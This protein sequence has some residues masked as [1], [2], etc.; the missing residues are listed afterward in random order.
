MKKLVLGISLFMILFSCSNKENHTAIEEKTTQNIE[1]SNV[2]KD[3]VLL[4]FDIMKV[5]VIFE[6]DSILKWNVI[7]DDLVDFQTEKSQTLHLNKHSVITTWVETE[8]DGDH[9]TQFADF[10][11][12][13][14]AS[15]IRKKDGTIF[16]V[17][18]T[19]SKN[20]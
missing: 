1:Y 19:I 8:T 3:T 15:V 17:S 20:E 16:T 18:G 14:V 11:N 10:E 4:D 2:L 5:K 9:I 6:S 13:V 7:D 12:N